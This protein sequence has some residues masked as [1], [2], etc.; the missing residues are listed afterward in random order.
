MFVPFSVECYGAWG[1]AAT[2]LFEVAT[3]HLHNYRDTE[4]F[5]WS[6]ARITNYWA[7]ALGRWVLH[8]MLGTQLWCASL[9]QRCC[10]HVRQQWAP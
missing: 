8:A 7:T 1:P 9:T 5:H 10:R 2:S 3:A 6:S 4:F